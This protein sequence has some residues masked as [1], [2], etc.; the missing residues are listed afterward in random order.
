VVEAEVVAQEQELTGQDEGR[1]SARI[2]QHPQWAEE[3]Q[4]EDEPGAAVSLA[5]VLIRQR[6]G[7]RPW[8]TSSAPA[9]AEGLVLFSELEVPEVP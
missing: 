8:Q 6:L 9:V 1:P 5:R 2:S 4:S 7:R 3:R